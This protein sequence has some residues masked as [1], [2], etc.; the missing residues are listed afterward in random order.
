[1]DL[2]IPSTSPLHLIFQA[3]VLLRLKT[4]GQ[5]GGRH[6]YFFFLGNELPTA[7]AANLLVDGVDLRNLCCLLHDELYLNFYS[8]F[9]FRIGNF[10]GLCPITRLH[11]A[12]GTNG[13]PIVNALCPNKSN[14]MICSR[15]L[16]FLHTTL[17]RL[18]ELAHGCV[19]CTTNTGIDLL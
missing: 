7:V 6:G 13:H 1:M 18:V 9:R 5:P 14:K 3:E 11:V 8:P 19:G 17:S 10:L 16:G 12:S 15:R 4:W 2:E